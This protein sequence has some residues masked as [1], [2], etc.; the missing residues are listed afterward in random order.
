MY[1]IPDLVFTTMLLTHSVTRE[2][3]NFTQMWKIFACPYHFTTRFETIT[4]V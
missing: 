4:L 3:W 1:E 2:G